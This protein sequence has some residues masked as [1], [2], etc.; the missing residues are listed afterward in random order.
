M[1]EIAAITL[2][3]SQKI[4]NFETSEPLINFLTAWRKIA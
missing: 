2:T 1:S 3:M 4:T